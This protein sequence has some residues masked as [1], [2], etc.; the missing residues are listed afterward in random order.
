MPS[1]S[2]SPSCVGGAESVVQDDLDRALRALGGDGL[3]C[4]GAGVGDLSKSAGGSPSSPALSSAVPPWAAARDASKLS[5]ARA[6][7]STGACGCSTL[8]LCTVSGMD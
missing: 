4:G 7:S 1:R 5:A 2:G 3:G 8:L 6:P